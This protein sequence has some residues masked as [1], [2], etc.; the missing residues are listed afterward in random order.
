MKGTRILMFIKIR[1][2]IKFGVLIR[3]SLSKDIAEII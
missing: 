2:S 3:N 1:A